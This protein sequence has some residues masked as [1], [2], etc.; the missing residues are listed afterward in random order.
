MQLSP[1]IVSLFLVTFASANFPNGNTARLISR[2]ESDPC[3]KS[4]GPVGAV[5]FNFT[6]CPLEGDVFCGCPELVQ[7]GPGCRACIDTVEGQG[8]NTT[9][10]SLSSIMEYFWVWCQCECE[11]RA[12][13]EGVFGT[14]CNFG[15]NTTCVNTAL[16]EKGPEC[17]EC[18]K[19]IDRWLAGTVQAD[20]DAAKAYF[21]TGV[22]GFPGMFPASRWPKL[23]VLYRNLLVLNWKGNI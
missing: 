10:V 13:A 9:Y 17:N 1:I 5:P 7:S 2:A 23:I 8:I 19:K 22:V 12:L 14:T 15:A 3:C 18:A 20:I 16:V 21:S 6:A 11:C 4:C